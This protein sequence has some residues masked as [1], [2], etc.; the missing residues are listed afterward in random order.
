MHHLGFP[1]DPRTY[2]VALAALHDLNAP[3]MIHLM[4][5]NPS[6][7]RAIEDGGF[8]VEQMV[9]LAYRVRRQTVPEL[10][11]KVSLLGHLIDFSQVTV[12][13]E[14]ESPWLDETER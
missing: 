9:S 2:E 5:N 12:I 8:V 6:K 3:P 7:R 1:P 10:E 11:A 14:R 4:S 13:E